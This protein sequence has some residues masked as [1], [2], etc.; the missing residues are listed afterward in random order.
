MA[1][2]WHGVGARPPSR[3]RRSPIQWVRRLGV[4]AEWPRGRVQGVAV[5]C[6]VLTRVLSCHYHRLMEARRG[7]RTRVRSASTRRTTT[8]HGRRARSSTPTTR[9]RQGCRR[10]RPEGRIDRRGAW[11]TRR[12]GDERRR[13]LTYR[14]EKDAW[15]LV[16]V[17][18]TLCSVFSAHSP[19]YRNTH[20][21]HL[22]S[23]QNVRLGT[24]ARAR[25]LA[26]RYCCLHAPLED[27]VRPGRSARLPLW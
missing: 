9:T 22:T 18:D 17:F 25:W 20:I 23:S 5:D 14:L 15:T 27:D 1:F 7:A 8:S 11:R 13:R 19:R 26:L 4:R 10:T 12:G 24:D 3:R 6:G 16:S 2:G 21:V